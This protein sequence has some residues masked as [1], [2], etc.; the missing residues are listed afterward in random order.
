VG[1]LSGLIALAPLIVQIIS[2]FTKL[3]AQNA[4]NARKFL[5]DIKLSAKQGN[6]SVQLRKEYKSL[7][8]EHLERQR[9]ENG[10][11]T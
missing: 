1:F 2:I 10:E 5:E 11:N 7:V 3:S 8:Q 9:K 4:E 6:A